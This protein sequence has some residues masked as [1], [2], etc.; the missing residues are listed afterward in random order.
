MR[1]LF[2][3]KL[4]KVTIVNRLEFQHCTSIDFYPRSHA[5]GGD[6]GEGHG[7]M[8]GEGMGEEGVGGEGMGEEGVGGGVE[9]GRGGWGEEWD[10]GEGEEGMGRRGMGGGGGW[11]RGGWGGRGHGRRP[12][13]KCLDVWCKYHCDAYWTISRGMA[14]T[15][16]MLL[17]L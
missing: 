11:G 6:G 2:T 12:K 16:A 17:Q 5:G 1:L 3:G 10:G 9:W 15:V 4:Y 7:G 13:P 8:G 14:Y